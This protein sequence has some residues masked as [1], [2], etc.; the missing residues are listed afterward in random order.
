[1]SPPQR[2]QIICLVGVTEQKGFPPRPA[3]SRP[4]CRLPP[5]HLSPIGAALWSRYEHFH[6]MCVVHIAGDRHAGC[7]MWVL[8]SVTSI[9]A[10][11][12]RWPRNAPIQNKGARGL[13]SLRSGS[14]SRNKSRLTAA[15]LRATAPVWGKAG[16][17]QLPAEGPDTPISAHTTH[18]RHRPR[19]YTARTH[20][21]GYFTGGP[22][23][24]AATPSGLMLNAR[25]VKGASPGF[26]H[27][28]TKPNGS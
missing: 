15:L 12:L 24:T 25:N 19:S 17:A 13:N 14:N 4:C 28:C 26:P 2:P 9:Q 6:S 23:T 22:G 1:M 7:V 21:G 5:C 27:W 10:I 16:H 11:A 20:S 3:R 8:I 18:Q